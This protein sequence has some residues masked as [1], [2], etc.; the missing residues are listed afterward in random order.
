MKRRLW[1]APFAGS[2]HHWAETSPLFV[3]SICDSCDQGQFSKV[4]VTVG[5]VTFLVTG[6][7]MTVVVTG[8]FVTVLVTVHFV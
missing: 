1:A 2:A 5:S 8:Q 7:S 6:Q 3:R 4:A